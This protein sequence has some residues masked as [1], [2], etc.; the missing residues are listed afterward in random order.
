MPGQ[1][2]AGIHLRGEQ[3]ATSNQ[4]GESVRFAAILL[5]ASPGLEQFLQRRI[6]FKT[7]FFEGF[8]G[9]SVEG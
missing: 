6:G 3:G 4:S 7:K 2:A 8:D 5:V 1:F 9:S